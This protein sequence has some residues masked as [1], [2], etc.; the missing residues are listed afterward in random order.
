M[1]NAILPQGMI[2]LMDVKVCYDRFGSTER[3][4]RETVLLIRL[5]MQYL[6]RT[7]LRSFGMSHPGTDRARTLYTSVV[8]DCAR[9]LIVDNTRITGTA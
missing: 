8:H 5:A 3:T 9:P 7:Q 2:G 4:M 1:D 6:I